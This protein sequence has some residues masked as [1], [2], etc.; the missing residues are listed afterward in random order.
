MHN[1]PAVTASG[2][3]YAKAYTRRVPESAVTAFVHKRD[4]VQE[5]DSCLKRSLLCNNT[6]IRPAAC[7]IYLHGIAVP[8]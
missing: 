3:L 4:C 8:I 1:K 6:E 5:P 7:Y 2:L